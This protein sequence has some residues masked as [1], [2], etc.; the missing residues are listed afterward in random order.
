MYDSPCH[1][2]VYSAVKSTWGYSLGLHGIRS[3]AFFH[4]RIKD[5][6]RDGLRS[7][8]ILCP[9]CF[10]VLTEKAIGQL[11]IL[12]IICFLSFWCYFN[13][14]DAILSYSGYVFQMK[15]HYVD[16]LELIHYY[17]HRYFQYHHHHHHNYVTQINNAI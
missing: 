3:S 7:H 6:E 15:S 1:L 4:I 13:I 9:F 5:E 16:K 14:F 12:Q 17:H 11:D 2:H 10:P 8:W